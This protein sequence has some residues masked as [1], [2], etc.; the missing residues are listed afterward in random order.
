MKL[1]LIALIPALAATMVSALPAAEVDFDTA[2]EKRDV[3]GAGYPYFTRRTNSPCA[4]SNGD[5]HFCGCDR[6]GIVSLSSRSHLLLS[7]ISN[8]VTL[9]VQCLQGYW[10]EIAG[11]PGDRPLCTAGE[12]GMNVVMEP[13]TRTESLQVVLIAEGRTRI[14][15]KREFISADSTSSCVDSTRLQIYLPV[16]HTWDLDSPTTFI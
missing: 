1:S 5:R 14:G 16:S 11:C 6:T 13:L 8:T 12:Q 3:C 9:Q 15:W 2:L 7:K 4:S 10:R